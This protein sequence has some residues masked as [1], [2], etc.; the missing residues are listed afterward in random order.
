MLFIRLRDARAYH[1]HHIFFVHN[2]RIRG[3]RTHAFRPVWG[4]LMLAHARPNDRLL[5]V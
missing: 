5:I 4:S 2:R 1:F 3:A